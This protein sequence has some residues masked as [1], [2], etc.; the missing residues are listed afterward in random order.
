MRSDETRILRLVERARKA[1]ARYDQRARRPLVVEFAGVPKAGKTSTIGQIAAFFKRCGFRVEVVIERASVCP[2]RDKKHA[3]FNI[4]T[5]C[6]TLAQLLERTQDPPQADDPQILILDRGLF[7]SLCWLS[8]MARLS[9]IRQKER[10]TVESFLLID[11]WC[12]RISGVVVMSASPDDSMARERGHLPVPGAG[13]SI[14][15]TKVL[16]QMCKT[17]AEVSEKHKKVFRIISVDT[18]SKSLR[19]NPQKTCEVIA[20]QM[21]NWVE[22]HLREDILYVHKDMLVSCFG[23]KVSLRGKQA[24]CVRKLFQEKG[25]FQPREVVEQDES[26]VQALPVVVVR[27]KTG[28]VL[29]LR[30]RERTDD[31]PLHEKLV[32][33]AG[34]HVR[35]EDSHNGEAIL[36]AAHRELHEE[37]RLE[38][39]EDRLALLGAVYVDANGKTA[40][41]VAV[42]FEWRAESDDV[43]VSLSSAEFFERRGTS[44]SGKFVKIDDLVREVEDGTMTEPWSIEIVRELLPDTMTRVAHH[45][46]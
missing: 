1:S 44:L 30:R 14:M 17:T 38:V 36:H 15:N 23:K 27:N 45:L 8:M 12:K 28:D 3:N 43:A 13:G 29:R 7:D 25:K 46:F 18:S 34:G 35:Y 22:E 26:L 39:E 41:H 9:R 37:L 21:L 32:L 11:D 20:D 16:E 5:A 2:I 6:T 40:R 10:K 42:V 24:E 4:W 31:N 33:W 19:D